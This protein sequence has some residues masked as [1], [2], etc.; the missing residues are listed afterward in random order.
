MNPAISPTTGPGDRAAP[1]SQHRDPHRNRRSHAG[2]CERRSGGRPDRLSAVGSPHS[3]HCAARRQAA[4]VVAAAD[5][6]G[7]RGAHAGQDFR[8]TAARGRRFA[9]RRAVFLFF[10]NRAG[11]L[12]SILISVLLSAVLIAVMAFL[13]GGC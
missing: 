2:R 11:C 6:G 9:L 12:K 10:S 13:G 7:R 5:A 8:T 4:E 3:G 1:N